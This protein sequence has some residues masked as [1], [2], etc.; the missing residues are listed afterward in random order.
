M[1]FLG[2]STNN[3]STQFVNETSP[4]CPSLPPSKLTPGM[5]PALT[6]SYPLS[7]GTGNHIVSPDSTLGKL[8]YAPHLSRDGGKG[9]VVNGAK[10]FLFCDTGTY[11]PPS[12]YGDGEFT[13]FVS[14]SAAVDIGDNAASGTSLSL[15]DGVGAWSDNAA[16]MRG[17]V[18]YTTGELGYNNAMQGADPISYRYA[19]WPES[20]IIP[21][22]STHG[23]VYAPVVYDEVQRDTGNTTFTYT[24]ATLLGISMPGDGGPVAERISN[25]IWQSWEVEWGTIGGARSWGSDGQGGNNGKV[26]L[27]GRTD[28]GLLLSRV[29]A[30]KVS[31]RD[32]VSCDSILRVADS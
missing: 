11:S 7:N 22:N 26:Y 18:P 24:G 31:D 29:D 19:I 32:S 10:V 25:R 4:P 9:G 30:D 28:G 6:D 3:P 8:Q 14:G 15:Q 13:G 27:F 21:L 12:G 2:A 5:D 20:A 17:L 23:L 16:R 1:T